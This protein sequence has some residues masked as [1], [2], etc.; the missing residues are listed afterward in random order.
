MISGTTS[1]KPT[2]QDNPHPASRTDLP[3]ISGDRAAT[4]IEGLDDIL[5]GGLPSRRLSLGWS[6]DG[7]VTH[8]HPLRPNSPRTPATL[9]STPTRSILTVAMTIAGASD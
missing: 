2:P 6:L 1:G 9:C 7:I 4:G 8:E 5:V 3:E